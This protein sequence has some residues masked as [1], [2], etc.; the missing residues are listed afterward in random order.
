MTWNAM[1]LLSLAIGGVLVD[2]LRIQPLFWAGG[3][4]LT[5]AGLLGL[6]LTGVQSVGSESRDCIEE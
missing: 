3:A 5:I 1:R 4:L 6:V 2:L